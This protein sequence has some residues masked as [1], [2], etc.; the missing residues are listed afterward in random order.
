MRASAPRTGAL[1]VVEAAFLRYRRT[2]RASVFS[3]FLNPVLLLLAMGVGLGSLVEEGPA[4]LPYLEWLA[5]GLLAGVAMQTAVGESSYP[6]MGALRWSK[7]YEAALATPV[8]IPDLLR[9]HLLWVLL[10]TTQVTVV[11]AAVM[12]A[13]GVGSPGG[14]AAA[15]VPAVATGLAFAG[16][17]TAYTANLRSENGLA[18]LFRFVV[19]PLFLFSGTYFPV[20]D[21]PGPLQGV[22]GVSPLFHGA[23][24]ARA[25]ALGLPTALPPAVHVAV[26]AAFAALGVAAARRV[27]RRRL[28]R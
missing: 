20:S 2:W 16:L 17:V 26:L 23:E 11:F 25:V 18:A 7:T 6:V 19:V 10:R 4:G 22:A 13:F 12:T 15:A 21:L 8:G 3:S 5:P 9:G 1:P 27:L 28:A 24:L 14:N